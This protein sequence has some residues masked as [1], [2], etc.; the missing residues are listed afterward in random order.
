MAPPSGD[1]QP[2]LFREVRPGGNLSVQPNSSIGKSTGID[3]RETNG[4]AAIADS[5]AISKDETAGSNLDREHLTAIDDLQGK[6]DLTEAPEVSP[7]KRY[8][9]RWF[10]KP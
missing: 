4:L 5:W 9:F 6:P 3:E 2:P 1:V 10:T 7:S 8:P